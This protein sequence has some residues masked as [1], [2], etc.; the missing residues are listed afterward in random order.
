MHE[1]LSFEDSAPGLCLLFSLPPLFFSTIYIFISNLFQFKLRRW[2]ASISIFSLL[3]ITC[4]AT[5]SLLYFHL[6]S[7]AGLLLL[8][9]FSIFT[10]IPKKAHYCMLCDAL[11]VYVLCALIQKK[12]LYS[13]LCRASLVC[14]PSRNKTCVFVREG[15]LQHLC[16][17]VREGTL[18]RS[19]PYR[20][21]P[22]VLKS[23]TF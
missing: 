12:A 15:S 11:L 8:S 7:C 4:I 19:E 1:A 18:K 5:I 13:M 16:F 2:P 20:A 10:C 14:V 6:P 17:S 23:L 22:Y 9:L 21:F 3:Y